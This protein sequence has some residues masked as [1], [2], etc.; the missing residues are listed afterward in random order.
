MECI[1]K[2]VI[3]MRELRR[4]NSYLEKCSSIRSAVKAENRRIENK[5]LEKYLP[6]IMIRMFGEVNPYKRNDGWPFVWH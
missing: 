5:T 3:V 6:K 1:I 4:L 2:E